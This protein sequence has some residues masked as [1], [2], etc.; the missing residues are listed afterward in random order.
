MPAPARWRTGLANLRTHTGTIGSVRT[1]LARPKV[2]LT[3]PTGR[4]KATEALSMHPDRGVTWGGAIRRPVALAVAVLLLLAANV[5]ATLAVTGSPYDPAADAYSMA[6]TTAILGAQ[7]WWDAGYTGAGVDV[8]VIDSGVAP[9][10]GLSAP[11]KVIY[12]PDLSLESQSPDLRNLD[13]Y[14][15]GTFM[16]GLIA[17][18][19]DNAAAPYSA[20]L[21][22]VYLGVAP[23]A[24]IVSLKV[25]T[26]DGGTDVSQVI[27][28]IDWVV[29]HKDDNDLNIRVLNLSYG[30]NSTQGYW[31]DPLAYA[32]EQAWKH[33]ILVVAAA[34]NTGYQKGHG[35]LGLAD[36]AYDPS[37]L[38]VGGLD[39]VGT[40]SMSDDVP[41][42]YTASCNRCR[43]PDVWTVGS[44][45][46]GLRVPNSFLDATHPEGVIDGRYFRGSGTSEAAAVT[47][48]MAALIL[49]KYPSFTPDQVKAFLVDN[50]RALGNAAGGPTHVVE[51][52]LTG[53]L[54]A[55]TPR[56]A[57]Q[58]LHAEG[59]GS[60]EAARGSDHLTRDGIVLQGE[61]DIFGAPFDSRSMARLE[62]RA[63]SW[64]AGTWNGN[65]W[66]GN[67]WTGNTWAGNTWTGNTWAGNTWTGNTW[68][69]NT[70][71]G[72]T[73]TGTSFSGNTWSGNTWATDTW[74]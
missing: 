73:W 56:K 30:T 16:A 50:G 43:N 70:W 7:A 49:Q 6:N 48:G 44:H 58:T 72:N 34:G 62:A 23:D 38:A 61:Q 52:D 19:D 53:M 25:A 47:S 74:D 42:S 65:T 20:D 51:T 1:A 3:C 31:N 35:A 21:P 41:G 28:A 24:R 67:T 33:G 59:T 4:S 68:T 57:T 54:R 39:A 69:G 26:A 32:V 66:T 45:L 18:R 12:G 27:A 13:T 11:G 71:T 29:Q 36:P 55:R 8:A 5:H 63:T 14:G 22:S 17:G 40:A 46:Q 2:S 37:L 60:L 10:E 64:S 15:H 9:V